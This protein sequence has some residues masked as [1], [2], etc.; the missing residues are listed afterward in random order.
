MDVTGIGGSPYTN[1][2]ESHNTFLRTENLPTCVFCGGVVAGTVTGWDCV[3]QSEG[4]AQSPET[5]ERNRM[6]NRWPVD[7]STFTVD[8]LDTSGFLKK[9]REIAA[10]AVSIGAGTDEIVPT[11]GHTCCYRVG[12]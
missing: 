6:K 7:L 10:T 8:P 11:T 2:G 3:N 4:T 9:V 1:S 5:I 12:G